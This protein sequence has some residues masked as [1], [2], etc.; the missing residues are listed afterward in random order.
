MLPFGRTTNQA[1][2]HLSAGKPQN[3][4]EVAGYAIRGSALTRTRQLTS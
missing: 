4:G 2:A 1:E 3:W